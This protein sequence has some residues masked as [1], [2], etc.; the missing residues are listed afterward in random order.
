[1]MSSQW[2]WMGRPR[3]HSLLVPDL[4]QVFELGRALLREVVK[5]DVAQL[6]VAGKAFRIGLPSR[7]MP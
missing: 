7:R 2:A 3:G 1:M 6:K 5:Q 4:G